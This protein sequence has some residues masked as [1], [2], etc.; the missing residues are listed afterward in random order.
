MLILWV[1]LDKSFNCFGPETTQL[2]K[3]EQ[4]D[5]PLYFLTGLHSRVEMR[6]G[7]PPLQMVS[8]WITHASAYWNKKLSISELL[9]LCL[10][11]S[12]IP[13]LLY[14]L[15]LEILGGGGSAAGFLKQEQ[16]CLKFASWTRRSLLLS[17]TGNGT[18]VV[19][20]LS[21][22]HHHHQETNKF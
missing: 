16:P 22:F 8:P 7:G 19:S 20:N 9:N 11:V 14:V 4:N 17:W 21:F 12:L 3:V 13:A 2:R 15:F 1:A 18:V 5:Y 10:S 6:K